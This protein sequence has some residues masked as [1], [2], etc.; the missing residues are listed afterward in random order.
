MEKLPLEEKEVGDREPQLGVRSWSGAR[1]W[2]GRVVV[3][4]WRWALSLAFYRP[5]GGVPSL[6]KH[7]YGCVLYGGTPFWF[8]L[9][10]QAL[11]F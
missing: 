4:E 11:P 9:L 7:P 3:G 6:E 5:F 1:G 10:F 2:G 8:V